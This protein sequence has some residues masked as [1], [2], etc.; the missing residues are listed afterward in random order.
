VRAP[1][2]VLLDTTHLTLA[3]QVQAVVDLVR[4]RYP[5]LDRVGGGG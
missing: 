1:D 2:A 5:S 3:Q 4:R